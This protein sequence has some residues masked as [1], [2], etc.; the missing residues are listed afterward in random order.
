MSDTKRLVQKT[1][2]GLRG[3]IEVRPAGRDDEDAAE[4]DEYPRPIKCRECGVVVEWDTW[5]Y[6][7]KRTTLCGNCWADVYGTD[8]DQ[9]G[10]Q[11]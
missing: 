9:S 8:M 5:D 11:P 7:S 10:R 4:D 6:R 2:P 1:L 3:E